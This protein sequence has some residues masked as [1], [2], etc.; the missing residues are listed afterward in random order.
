M[1]V[2]QPPTLMNN[3]LETPDTSQAMALLEDVEQ[4]LAELRVWQQQQFDHVEDVR[5]RAEELNE[6]E[7]EL[8]QK[9]REVEEREQ[10]FADR[11]DS[12]DRQEADVQARLLN[13]QQERADLDAKLSVMAEDRTALDTTMRQLDDD[14]QALAAMRASVDGDTKRLAAERKA[15]EA[16][17]RELSEAEAALEAQRT[18][19]E[20]ERTTL[21]EKLITLER[22][23]SALERSRRQ[24]AEEHAAF[25][26]EKANLASQ[27]SALETGRQAATAQTG[28]V[29]RQMDGIRAEMARLKERRRAVIHHVHRL[30]RARAAQRHK[31]EHLAEYEQQLSV[32]RQ[33]LSEKRSQFQKLLDAG[34][35]QLVA[36]HQRLRD[37][38]DRIAARIEKLRRDRRALKHALLRARANQASTPTAPVPEPQTEMLARQRRLLQDVHH[39]LAASEQEMI[40]K[41]ATRRAITVVAMVATALISMAAISHAASHR[42][43]PQTWRIATVIADATGAESGMDAA[44]LRTT[45]LSDALLTETLAQMNQRGDYLHESIEPLR[46]EL[47]PTLAV[48]IQDD[49]R[50]VVQATAVDQDRISKLLDGLGRAY[51]SWQRSQRGGMLNIDRTRVAHAPKAEAISAVRLQW[52]VTGIMFAAM[53]IVST[54]ATVL[55]RMMMLRADRMLEEGAAPVLDK[56]EDDK[57]WAA[58]E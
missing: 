58:G 3:R 31:A 16:S 8:L 36:Q 22:D 48:Q 6:L 28:D 26:I 49:G 5:R 2:R 23:R 54:L 20:H 50:F 9:A 14:R 53:V 42:L 7:V 13:V 39:A 17:R 11:Q 56:L 12:L 32:K 43:V 4:R 33:E 47:A 46:A 25:E 1:I 38:R 52:R 10:A 18:R 37:S 57:W 15:F 30:K 55:I 21:E 41:W 35:E 34:R 29:D 27:W 51:V 19:L 24:L 45:L 44:Q 40:R